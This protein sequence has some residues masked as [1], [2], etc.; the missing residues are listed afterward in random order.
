MRKTSL[1]HD[2]YGHIPMSTYTPEVGGLTVRDRFRWHYEKV[3]G[4]I[5]CSKIRIKYD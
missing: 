2:Q 3:Q 5:R 1:N 4:V